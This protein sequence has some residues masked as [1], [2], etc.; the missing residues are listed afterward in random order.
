[1]NFGDFGG[2]IIGFG[3]ELGGVGGKGDEFGELVHFFAE[4]FVGDGFSFVALGH[5]GCG[6]EESEEN[7][8]ELHLDGFWKVMIWWDY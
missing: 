6:E 4:G 7:F 8:G 2:V 5:D 3:F 1:M